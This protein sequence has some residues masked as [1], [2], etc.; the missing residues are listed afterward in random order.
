MSE[1]VFVC[2]SPTIQHTILFDSLERGEVNRS[3]KY[4][5]D[6]SGKAVNAARVFTQL[7]GRAKVI[8]PLG[9]DGAEA[10]LGLARGDGLSVESIRVPGAVRHCYTLLEPAMN[11]ARGAGDE[12]A[13]DARSARDADSA[14]YVATELV[15]GEPSAVGADYAS[16]SAELLDLAARCLS[17][18]DALVLSGSKPSFWG[19]TLFND[20]IALAKR[21]R[22]PT[23]ADFQG[24]DLLR[25]VSMGAAADSRASES[26]VPEIIKINE[27]EFCATFGFPFPMEERALAEAIAAKSRELS[28]AIAVTRGMNDTFAGFCGERYREPA[29]PVSAVNAIACGDSFAAGFMREWLA[30]RSPERALALGTECAAKNALS[31]RPGS[32]LDPALE[33]ERFPA[34][35]I[36]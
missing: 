2:L 24:P 13:S 21:A 36:P 32:I 16:L 10:F 19:K 22:C 8:A 25:A 6:A 9:A 27:A 30:S 3:R 18:A 17:H 33:T 11:G 26:R 31:F 34:F 20:L 12:R 15:V 35:A 7:G 14:R 28:C 5:L 4:R 29:R 23:L 1:T